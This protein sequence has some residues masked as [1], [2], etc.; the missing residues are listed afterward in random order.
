M[1]RQ[2]VALMLLDAEKSKIPIL[3]V[4]S[5][6]D[7]SVE[8]AY[9]IQLLQIEK[10]LA[11]GAS[12]K[13]KKIGLTSKAMQDLLGVHT[14]DYG[15]ILDT[16]IFEEGKPVDVELFIQPKI[17]FEIAFILKSD[18]IGAN[19]TEEDVI[20]ATDYIVPAIEIID[21]RIEDWKIKFED[22]VAD[23][24]SSAGAVLGQK[25]TTVQSID[26]SSIE[27]KAFKNGKL[28]DSATGSAVMG[29]PINAVIW[30]A[31]EL[32]RYNIPLRAGEF[33]LSGALSKA[34]PFE[35]GDTF[36]AD[37]GP[38]GEVSISFEK[39]GVST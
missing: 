24:G 33:I 25:K 34:V 27:M 30:L 2:Q 4:T 15:H 39:I 36:T 37:F 23:N 31:K 8:D 29:N 9:H 6:T 7:I 21:S 17:E 12:I 11:E 16:M 28:I 1:D 3:P 13:G 14:P 38:F 18:L 32:S 20:E 26:L 5:S 19:I 22:T 35:A 10:K